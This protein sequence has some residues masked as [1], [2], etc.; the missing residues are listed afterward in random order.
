M[1]AL[2]SEVSK[3]SKEWFCTLVSDPMRALPPEFEDLIYGVYCE[4]SFE[5]KLIFFK[6]LKY[7]F[8]EICKKCNFE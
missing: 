8:S 5:K 1:A 2:D 6:V 4:V 7:F 3:S